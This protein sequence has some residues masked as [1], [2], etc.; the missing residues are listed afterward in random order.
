MIHIYRYGPKFHWLI[1][2]RTGAVF[3]K[4]AGSNTGFSSK[5][6]CYDN[7]KFIGRAYGALTGYRVIEHTTGVPILT[8]ATALPGK[9]RLL[10]DDRPLTKEE[11]LEIK[12]VKKM[13][14]Q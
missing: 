6:S 2:G 9:I 10:V 11:Q 3:N 12:A 14:A 4:E 7:V 8:I 13:I 1:A 5:Q